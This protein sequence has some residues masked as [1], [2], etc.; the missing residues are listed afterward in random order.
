MKQSI[1]MHD[2]DDKEF[3]S[4]SNLFLERYI[5]IL[6]EAKEKKILTDSEILSNLTNMR[7]FY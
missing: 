7:G 3:Y 5:I 6:K 2:F 1:N 4:T